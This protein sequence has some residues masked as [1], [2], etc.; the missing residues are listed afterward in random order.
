MKRQKKSII[1][2]MFFLFGISTMSVAQVKKSDV[3]AMLI[4]AG[5]TADDV[6]TVGVTFMP[7]ISDG[8]IFYRDGTFTDFKFSFTESGVMLTK[9][10]GTWFYPFSSM[11]SMYV[12]DKLVSITLAI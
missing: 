8:R 7:Y 12:D 11:K 3:E 10:T 4:T 1:I 2:T 5:I 9:G 6:K